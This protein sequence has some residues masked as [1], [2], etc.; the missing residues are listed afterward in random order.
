MLTFE[1]IHDT[2]DDLA[3]IIRDSSIQERYFKDM[4]RLKRSLSQ[5]A[6][7]GELYTGRLDGRTVAVLRLSM[8]GFCG[9]YPYIKLLGVAPD[10]RGRGIGL[11]MLDNAER[12]ARESGARKI[13]LMVSDFNERAQSFYREYGYEPLGIIRDAV[14]DGIDEHLMIKYLT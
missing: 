9:L 12:L 2:S 5:A 8:R 7:E 13:T 11:F 10:C 3:G 14:L 6:E 4:D 1:K